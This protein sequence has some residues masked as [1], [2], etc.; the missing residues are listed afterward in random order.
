MFKEHSGTR[1]LQQNSLNKMPSLST[2]HRNPTFTFAEDTVDSKGKL[3]R[4]GNESSMASKE[5]TN[6][7]PPINNS[8]TM[9]ISS[10]TKNII[11]QSLTPQNNTKKVFIKKELTHFV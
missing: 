5:N 4:I 7:K 10:S 9:K 6:Q 8:K 11:E 1:E 3:P 2:L